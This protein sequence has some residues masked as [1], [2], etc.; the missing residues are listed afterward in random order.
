MNAFFGAFTAQ[1]NIWINAI[2]GQIVRLWRGHVGFGQPLWFC[3]AAGFCRV[4]TSGNDELGASGRLGRALQLGLIVTLAFIAVF[5]VAGIV[6]AG[7]GRALTQYVGWA[8]L[9]IGAAVVGLGLF[10]IVTRKSVFTNATAGV[11][12]QRSGTLTGVYRGFCL[13]FLNENKPLVV[14]PN[15]D[16]IK[17]MPMVPL[18]VRYSDQFPIINRVLD[19]DGTTVKVCLTKASGWSYEKEWRMVDLSGP[20]RRNF[21]P[22]F[23]KSVIF[24]CKMTDD[25]KQ[26][27]RKWCE[28]RDPTVTFHEA[29]ISAGSYSLETVPV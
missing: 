16:A 7:G 22:H 2:A 5:G 21:L 6:I 17:N 20:G 19:D 25:H 9:V 23:L 12:V 3:H 10:Q 24:G 13:K 8:G 18:K 11:R 15:S 27:V 1:A 26:L 28:G 29:R 4:P 14:G